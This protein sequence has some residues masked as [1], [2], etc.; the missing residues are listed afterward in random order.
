MKGFGENNQPKREKISNNKQHL[1]FD[2]L[3]KKA[4]DLQSQ[5]MKFEAAKYYAYLIK[6]GFKDIAFFELWN[7]SK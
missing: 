5:G 7:I 6:Q 4:F 1:N 2:H 3:I